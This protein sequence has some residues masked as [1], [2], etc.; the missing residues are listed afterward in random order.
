MT[1]RWSAPN[2]VN[3]SAS[4]GD[5]F[6]VWPAGSDSYAHQDL[7]DNWDTLDAIIGRPSSGNWPPSAGT[8]GGIYK[9]VALLQDERVPIGTVVPWFRPNDSI[10]LPTNWAACDGSTLTVGNHNFPGVAG[11]VVLPDLRNKFILGADAAKTSG[12]AAALVT[13]AGI[14]TFAGAPG[15]STVGGSNKIVQSIAQMPVHGHTFTGNALGAHGHSFTGSALGPHSHYSVDHS[16]NHDFR[17]R[18]DLT[19][20]GGSKAVADIGGADGATSYYYGLDFHTST[21]SAGT[22]VGSIS[23]TGAGTPSGSISNTGSGSPMDNRPR[24]VG[25]IFICKVLNATTI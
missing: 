17:F 25:L 16:G 11:S 15:E 18:N 19:G 20:N 23:S 5:R 21:D 4:T 12:T 8:D 1:D 10:P 14:D 2:D 9:E 7:A 22:P 3:L 6:H 24:W 13:D